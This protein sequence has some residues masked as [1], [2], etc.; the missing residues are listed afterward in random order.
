MIEVQPLALPQRVVDNDTGAPSLRVIRSDPQPGTAEDKG[1]IF[2]KRSPMHIRNRS[3]LLWTL[4]S[5]LISACD[6]APSS[7]KPAPVDDRATLQ[8]LADSYNDLAE[9][10][11]QSPT[12]LPP[13]GRKQ[14]VEDVFADAGYNYAATLHALAESKA[15]YSSQNVIDLTELL[16]LPHRNTASVEQVRDIYSTQEYNDIKRIEKRLGQ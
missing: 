2:K 3:I 4:I 7:T 6:M 9:S 8:T 12:G 15:D 1:P 10:F 5:L 14:F 13:D 16:L 11:T